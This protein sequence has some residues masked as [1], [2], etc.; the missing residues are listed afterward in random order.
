CGGG[1]EVS[2]DDTAPGLAL[3]TSELIHDRPAGEAALDGIPAALHHVDVE[4]VRQPETEPGRRPRQLGDQ[5][6]GP[7]DAIGVPA[8]AEDPHD[9]LLIE[10]VHPRLTTLAKHRIGAYAEFLEHGDE[11]SVI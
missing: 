5:L 7:A 4:H 10:G 2:F 3:Q 1:V 6:F 9:P 8:W 11:P